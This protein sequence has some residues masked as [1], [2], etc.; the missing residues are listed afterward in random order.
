M[1]ISLVN[2]KG[3]VGKTTIAVNL[4]YCLTSG[5]HKVLLIDSDIQGS[6]LQWQ[7]IA[8]NKAFHV[9]H[10][11]EADLH[12]SINELGAGYR[13]V[14][15]DSPPGTGDISISALMTSN[16]AIIPVGPSPLDIW[17]SKETVSLIKEARQYNK[18]L[19]GKLLICKKIVGTRI[20]REAREAMSGYKLQ[21][22]KTEISQRV[23]YVEAMIS[24]LSVVQ[25]RPNSE[26][27]REVISLCDEI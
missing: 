5:G 15:I 1:I 26:A 11:P 21:V 3:G 4:S 24:G 2:Q 12:K 10:Y 19:R 9:I 14:V 27:S 6:C 7:S 8:D 25:Y 17:A 20:G 18:K 13:H 23:A 16:L 22:F